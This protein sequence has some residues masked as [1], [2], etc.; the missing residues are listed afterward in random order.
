MTSSSKTATLTRESLVGS[1]LADELLAR[2]AK[3]APAYDRDGRFCQEEFDELKA[4]GYFLVPL[5]RELGGDGLT[6][7]EVCA[8]QCRLGYHAAASALAIQPHLAWLGVA[9]DLW[10]SGDRSLVWLLEAAEAGDTFSASHAASGNDVPLCYAT[11]T[12]E[13]V[14]GGYRFSGRMSHAS[15]GPV[16]SDLGIHAMDLADP[17][18]PKMVHAFLSRETGGYRIVPPENG[19][20]G[21]RATG[22]DDIA[23]EG[24][25]V[26]DR[27]VARIVPAGFRGVDPFVV[28]VFGWTLLR[29]AN[30]YYGLARRI[31]DEAVAGLRRATSLAITRGSMIHHTGCQ[32]AVAKMAI[33]LEGVEPHLDRVAR[34]W[35]DGMHN[36]AASLPRLVAAHYRAVEAAWR[37]ADLALHSRADLTSFQPRTSSVWYATPVSAASIRPAGFSR[38]RSSVNRCWGSTWTSSRGG[39]EGIGT[40]GQ[41]RRVVATATRRDIDESVLGQLRPSEMTMRTIHRSLPQEPA[42]GGPAWRGMRRRAI[43]AGH[44]G[45]RTHQRL[46]RRSDRGVLRRVAGLGPRR[47]QGQHGCRR[48]RAHRGLSRGRVR[49]LGAEWHSVFP[50]RARATA[51]GG[52]GCGRCEHRR[53]GGR[54]LHSDRRRDGGGR[55]A[56]HNGHRSPVRPGHR[57]GPHCV[58]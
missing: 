16:W 49:R 27:H 33:E 11:T 14:D 30:V 2:C 53:G 51:P 58:G 21:M 3:R 35:S 18:A 19:V 48:I 44:V 6:L 15:L 26:P 38:V 41:V 37:V 56:A 55:A 39:G 29:H 7:S 28:G 52:T 54:A 31:S 57:G 20:I 36:G 8:E 17:G 50:R 23:L 5:P 24:A 32:D 12:A 4:A 13:R 22:S 1:V 40:S 25:F 10:R 43:W 42:L 47:G 45:P 34:E 9:V 46:R